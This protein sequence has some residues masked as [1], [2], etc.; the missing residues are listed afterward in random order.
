MTP[1]EEAPEQRWRRTVDR[2]NRPA[3]LKVDR[4]LRDFGY[5]KLDAEVGDAIEARLADVALAVAPSLRDATANEVVTIY[6]NDGAAPQEAPAEAAAPA[7]DPASAAAPA[8]AADVA[9]MVTYLKQQVLDARAEAERLRNELERRIA[10]RADAEADAQAIIAEQVAALDAQSRQIAELAAALEQ[11]R[12]AL[13]DTR[14]EIR[15]A[16]GELQALPEPPPPPL[17]E[18]EATESTGEDPLDD[19][20]RGGG[21]L[22]DDVSPVAEEPVVEEIPPVG[23]EPVVGQIPSVGEEP[24]VGQIPSVGEEPVGQIPSVG[25]EPVGQVPS[26]G[27]EPVVGEVPSVGGEPVGQVP[28][29]GGEPVGQVPSVGGEPVVGAISSVGGEPVVGAISSVGEEPV[30][31]EPPPIAPEP[32]VEEIP[33]VAEEPVAGEPPPVTRELVEAP[34][35]VNDEPVVTDA[36]PRGDE[37]TDDPSLS[38]AE[39]AD[40]REEAEA[41]WIPAALRDN[42][43]KADTPDTTGPVADAGANGAGVQPPELDA[44][45]PEFDLDEP[46]LSAKP[47]ARPDGGGRSEADLAA[48]QPGA[49]REAG[50]NTRPSANGDLDEFADPALAAASPADDDADPAAEANAADADADPAAEANAAGDDADPAAEANAA[51][52]DADPAAEANAAG[53]DD[54]LTGFD[55]FLYDSEELYDAD[56]SDVPGDDEQFDRPAV[57]GSA[58]ALPPPPPAP[59]SPWA[60]EPDAEAPPV[61]ARATLGKVLRGRGGGRGR[62][63]WQ[64]SCSIC[65]REPAEHRRKDLE[66]AGWNLDEEAAA[67]PQCRGLG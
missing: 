66:A 12:Q 56:A 20:A 54:L 39:S 47:A 32:V 38:G 7:A 50:A 48:W 22:G 57:E 36:S 28:S 24:V 44:G 58:T 52:D 42:R 2:R 9:Q 60:D 8:A 65:G 67:C 30:V 37:P 14:D 51:G 21:E 61:H 26:V 49:A 40:G 43:R 16:V 25:E 29:V 53:D 17:E 63:R 64:G 11:T 1:L 41:D 19:F 5:A 18:D 62:G 6:A 59:P 31:E 35:P 34:P 15:R 13:A 3:K 45:A 55:D 27:E 4:L 33:V 10:T 23:E 46:P